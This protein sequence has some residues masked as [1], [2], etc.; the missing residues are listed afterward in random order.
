LV[1]I[2]NKLFGGEEGGAGLFFHQFYQFG[3]SSVG[4]TGRLAML[5]AGRLF[6]GISSFGTEVAESRGIRHV[7]NVNLVGAGRDNL[8]HLDA[9]HALGEIMFLLAGDLA[10]MAAGAPI[11]LYK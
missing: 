3:Y 2:I 5:N 9:D 4:N 1:F 7:V 10:G 6:A 8:I 11:V